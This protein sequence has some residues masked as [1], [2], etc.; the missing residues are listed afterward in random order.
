MFEK[1]SMNAAYSRLQ[2]FRNGC[3]TVKVGGYFVVFSG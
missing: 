1:S 2:L 3:S